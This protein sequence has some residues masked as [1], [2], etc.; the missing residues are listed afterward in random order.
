M[1]QK[2]GKKN[3]SFSTNPS[4]ELKK[5]TWPTKEILL[6]SSFL[7]LLIMIFFVIYIYILD[8][9]FSLLFDNLRSIYR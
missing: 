1:V 4:L 7:I 3:L 6:K 2:K 9:G 5:V 8:M